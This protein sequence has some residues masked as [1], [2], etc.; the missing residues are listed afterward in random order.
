MSKVIKTPPSD[1]AKFDKLAELLKDT[2]P[3]KLKTLLVKSE[4]IIFRVTASDK[5]AME[6]IAGECRLTVTDYLTRLHSFAWL[7]W[8]ER[9]K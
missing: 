8:T 1:K 2:S 9:G 4:T 3:A 6:T 5:A 7:R